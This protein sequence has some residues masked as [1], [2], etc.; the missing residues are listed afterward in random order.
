[1]ITRHFIPQELKS[2]HMGYYYSFVATL[3]LVSWESK[4]I[5][6]IVSYFSLS[7]FV[8]LV[9]KNEEGKVFRVFGIGLDQEILA[10][11]IK[12]FETSSISDIID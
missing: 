5:L 10:P 11:K 3:P 7:C 4:S 2:P 8:C 9:S 6:M 1:M 12:I